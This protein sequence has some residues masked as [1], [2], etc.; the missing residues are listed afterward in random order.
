MINLSDVTPAA[1]N[2][3]LNVRWQLDASGNVSAY[4][5][6]T[7]LT[8]APVSGVLTVDASLGNSFLINVNA[9]I[10][11]MVINN[12]ADGQEITLLWAQDGAGHP[13]TL[14]TFLLGATAIGT[15]ANKHTCQKFTYNSGDNNWYATGVGVTGM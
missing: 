15:A 13:V 7:K 2:G 5:S 6:N 8:L 9:T 1:I 12:P 4:A 11:S 14:S 3:G 10:A